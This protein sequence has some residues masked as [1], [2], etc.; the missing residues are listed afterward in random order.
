M[1]VTNYLSLTHQL[2]RLRRLVPHVRLHRPFPSLALL[3]RANEFGRLHAIVV[4][5]HDL[6]F[7]EFGGPF[8]ILLKAGDSFLISQ[9][10]VIVRR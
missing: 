2:H 7:P 5:L 6:V 1:T 9:I 10:V 8:Q 4:R 3:R